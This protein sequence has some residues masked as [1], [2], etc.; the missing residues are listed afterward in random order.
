MNYA[1]KRKK[2]V[3]EQLLPRGIERADVLSAFRK[4]PRHLFV[5]TSSRDA[6][7]KDHPLQIGEGQ[8]ISQPYIVA[9]MTQLLPPGASRILE[10]GTG[11]GYQ[12]AILAEL[13]ERVYTVERKAPLQ[14]KARQALDEAGYENIE[15]HIGDGTLGL[16]E[17][18]PFDGIIVTAAAPAV[19][20]PLTEQLSEAGSIVIPVGSMYGQVLTVV[21]KNDKGLSYEEICGCMFVPLVGKEGWKERT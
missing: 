21:T 6:S 17:A 13:Y 1:E 12:A 7:Y 3:E 15:F 2:M 20:E 16:P 4:V 11:S 18:S 9:L 19:P 10:I 8:T 14:E 5:P